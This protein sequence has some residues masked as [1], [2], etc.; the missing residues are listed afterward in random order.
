M[1]SK[2]DRVHIDQPG[3]RPSKQPEKQDQVAESWEDEDDD[4]SSSSPQT[5]DDLENPNSSLSPS[6]QPT[7]SE[8]SAL[9]PP[10]PTP[11]MPNDGDS[12]VDWS[13]ATVL[14]GG[15]PKPYSPP[16]APSTPRSD[17]DQERRRPEKTTAAAGRMIAAS[18]GLKAPQK[19]EEQKLYDQAVREREI[20]RRNREKEERQ[21]ERD[22]DERAKAAMWDG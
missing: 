16:A 1:D 17:S 19:T 18:L 8:N 5:E 2:L 11:V 12:Y 22:A 21:R 15:R 13:P 14:G 6:L 9:H 7:K 4:F 3:P 20:K 10:P